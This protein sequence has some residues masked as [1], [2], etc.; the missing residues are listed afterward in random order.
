[1]LAIPLK[2]P[3]PAAL[4][5]GFE[6]FLKKLY[7]D[8][9]VSK[10]S[11]DIS[12]I[13]QLRNAACVVGTASDQSQIQHLYRYNYHLK[14]LVPK[15][16]GYNPP[17]RV[18]LVW[19]EAFRPN[20][21]FQSGSLLFEWASI[22]W[23]LAAIES[24]KGAMGNRSTDEGIRVASLNF[25]QAGGI[26]EFI[27]KEILPKMAGEQ[28][29]P[30]FT[31]E[32]LILCR[33]VIYI[34]NLLSLTYFDIQLM[35]AQA[36]TCFY[37]KS[38]KEKKAGTMKASIVCKLASQIVAFYNS[39]LECAR[40]RLVS[41]VVDVS[42]VHHMEFQRDSFKGLAEYWQ[43][44]AHHDDATSSGFGYGSEIC[45]LRKA[46]RIIS[47][48]LQ[49]GKNN[50]I[51][52][53]LIA[54][55]DNVYTVVQRAR[56]NAE[57]D[58]DGV[59]HE[60]IP[61]ESSLTEVPPIPMVRCSDMPEY[62]NNEKPFFSDLV[63]KEV[64]VLVTKY[65][66]STENILRDCSGTA[67]KATNEG[68]AAL[69]ELGLPGS[70]ELFKSGGMLPENLWVKIQRIQSLGGIS[71]L[72]AKYSNLESASARARLTME[73]I[74]NSLLRESSQMDAFRQ[75]HASVVTPD[76]SRLQQDIRQN[77]TLLRDAHR[78]ASLRNQAIQ[79]ELSDETFVSYMR[80]LFQS[81]AEISNMLP[82]ADNTSNAFINTAKLEEKLIQFA[83]LFESRDR[84]L[85][86]LQ[87]TSK[88]D[89][90]SNMVAT[91]ASMTPPYAD[92]NLSRAVQNQIS[93]DFGSSIDAIHLTI[94]Q[95]N[96]LFEEVGVLVFVYG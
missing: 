70:L 34:F 20:K 95:Q 56:M 68:R 37:E 63:P 91:L 13:Q 67:S 64:K 59:Y 46:E 71:E 43:A 25:Q 26:F 50:K 30:E 90:T 76:I 36:Q 35:L 5:S 74:E 85:Q 3:S 11:G 81:K 14:T 38:V 32:C 1:M 92:D 48:V 86:Q 4:N 83:N 62:Y 77:L 54:A 10:F 2:R 24:Y 12:A 45:R 51:P 69:S 82:K 21:N 29:T 78:D 84:L 58:N 42:W 93:A 73:A 44:V 8:T 80:S 60:L 87:E 49:Y 23:N 66:E 39:A 88:R 52:A 75:R 57:K 6:Q 55:T 96:D 47:N 72:N 65:Q 22:L 9:E 15:L 27:R 19:T 33:Q 7:D 17:F 79:N 89:V 61:S 53:S 40:H 41:G 18:Q 28:N 94:A 31:D 16:S